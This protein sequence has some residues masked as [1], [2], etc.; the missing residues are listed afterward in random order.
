MTSAASRVATLAVSVLLLSACGGSSPE[1]T[2]EPSV[3]TAAS[4]VTD[5]RAGVVVISDNS[6]WGLLWKACDGPTL[7]YV[8]SNSYKGGPAVVPNSPECR[9]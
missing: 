3:P 8:W 4:M 1:P 9:P 7:V 2:A 6:R 5:P